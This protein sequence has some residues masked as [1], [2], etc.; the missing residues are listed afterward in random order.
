MSNEIIIRHPNH[1]I[2]AIYNN[3][4]SK[5]DEIVILHI[6]LKIRHK[7][8]FNKY[9]AIKSE[10]IKLKVNELDSKRNYNQYMDSIE[11]LSKTSVYYVKNLVDNKLEKTVTQ[12]I[13][14]VR[15]TP[16]N[17]EVIIE[18]PGFTIEYLTYLKGGYSD[19]DFF[20]FMRLKSKYSI[21][22][23]KLCCRFANLGGFNYYEEELRSLVGALET[24]QTVSDLKRRAIEVAKRELK[25]V[26]D[27]YFEYSI[28]KRKD[29]VFFRFK[30][31]SSNV[32]QSIHSLKNDELMKIFNFLLKFYPSSKNDNAIHYSEKIAE[33]ENTMLIRSRLERLMSEY[34]HDKKSKQST[35]NLLNNVI[36]PE[37]NI[38]VRK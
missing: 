12:F 33:N 7:E 19:I 16:N 4:L 24:L 35:L 5:I 32:Q 18:L 26:S 38:E 11:K 25:E 9:V 22:L 34:Y 13:S 15:K 8:H 6:A 36:F 30:I 31:L 3:E 37:Y 21:K 10:F 27:I 29:G 2:T 17:R 20:V 14:G 28:D 23:Y 1:I